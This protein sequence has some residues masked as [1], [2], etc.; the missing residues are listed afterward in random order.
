MAIWRKEERKREM[1]NSESSVD[2]NPTDK[3]KISPN[4][5]TQSPES[6]PVHTSKTQPQRAKRQKADKKKKKHANGGYDITDGPHIKRL[7]EQAID[8]YNDSLEN[9][10]A[11]S[12]SIAEIPFRDYEFPFENMVFEGGGAKGQVYIGCL[13]VFN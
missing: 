4:Q 10:R 9:M 5:V 13:K 8:S 6:K 11:E 12:E 3:T 1:G 2:A 7:S